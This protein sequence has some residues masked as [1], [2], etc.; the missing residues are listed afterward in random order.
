[1]AEQHI[2]EFNTVS[3]IWETPSYS[4]STYSDGHEVEERLLA[5]LR[6]CRDVSA[7]SEEL[8]AHI[9]DW[10]TE[11]HLSP[12]RHNLL[13]PFSFGPSD[14][15]LELGC[16]CGALTRYLGETG[17]TVIAVEG[18]HRRA[19]I[20]AERCRDLPNVSIYCD[21][22]I[23]FQASARFAYV[24][25]IGVLEY[26]QQFIPGPNPI[27][28]CLK[29]AATFLQDEGALLLAIENQLGL[30]YF[31]GCSE[32]HMGV[33]YFGIKD[34]YSDTTPITFGRKELAARLQSAGFRHTSFFYPF[35][36]Y[37]LPEV[38]FA[39][40]ALN[41]KGFQAADLL[42]RVNSRDYGHS[43]GRAF[44]ENLV[45]RSL[46]RNGLLGDLA[47]S[48]LVQARARPL[49]QQPEALAHVFST[50]RLA[51]FAT[52]TFFQKKDGGIRVCK[53]ALHNPA[54]R[55]CT[56]RFHHQPAADASYVPGELY[57]IELQRI[58][59]RQGDVKEVAQWASA[60]IQHLAKHADPQN[61]QL[62][63]G[64]CLDAI[65]ANLVHTLD[66]NLITI[67]TEWRLASPIPCSWVWIRGLVNAWASS[68][69]SPFFASSN[70][71]EA[72]TR[73]FEQLGIRLVA[74]D[75]DEA[76]QLED[77]FQLAVN[78]PAWRG[79]RFDDVLSKTVSRHL[80]EPT[81]SDAL[82]AK[83]QALDLALDEISRVKSTWSWQLTKPLRLIWNLWARVRGPIKAQL[84]P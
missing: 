76:A 63:P 22:L 17:A 37:K 43:S 18:S 58:M 15:I 2:Y 46:V 66:G 51:C 84:K 30:K 54:T 77:E 32:D 81:L 45:W 68:P 65:P 64:D 82:L 57:A 79:P 34:L 42:Y 44:H 62:L 13:R 35:P 55:S 26:A 52:K 74:R 61:P 60:W 83:Q 40:A 67:D 20:A 14:C 23:D 39:E 41:E 7:F 69:P 38:L 6:Q 47:N 29:K 48:F 27:E 8:R 5:T 80:L 3:R 1:M 25:L 24:T 70:Y 9:V 72:I 33:P 12:A 59:S 50:R 16:G 21:N 11:Y 49:S 53:T 56:T 4:G 78:G 36:D 73:V 71:R 75:F 10:P 31:A 19:A 28:Q